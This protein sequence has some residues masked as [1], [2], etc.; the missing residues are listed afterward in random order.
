M[1]E[2]NMEISMS[3]SKDHLLSIKEE[4]EIKKIKKVDAVDACF[5]IGD[6]KAMLERTNELSYVVK[7]L[8]NLIDKLDSL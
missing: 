7:S 3:D 2:L 5:V 4:L 8:E 6:W 1:F